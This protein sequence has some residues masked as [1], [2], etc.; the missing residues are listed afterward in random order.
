MYYIF[1]IKRLIYSLIE[2]NS[3]FSEVE[4][5]S[6]HRFL[7]GLESNVNGKKKFMI[8]LTF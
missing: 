8:E 1:Y 6:L 4:Q 5:S 2:D 3:L 7:D